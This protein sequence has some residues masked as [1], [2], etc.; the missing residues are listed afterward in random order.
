MKTITFTNEEFVAISGII[1]DRLNTF[2]K[3]IASKPD[4]DPEFN[5]ITNYITYDLYCKLQEVN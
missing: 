3:N 2:K 4:R 1:A 5:D